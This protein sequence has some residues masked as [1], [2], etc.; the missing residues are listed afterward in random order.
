MDVTFEGKTLLGKDISITESII[1]KLKNNYIID[2]LDVYLDDS[3]NKSLT[4]KLKT[5]KELEN[6]FNEFSSNLENI[7]DNISTLKVPARLSKF[8]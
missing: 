5:V 8:I 1:L 2:N 7:F 6:S 3:S 4:L